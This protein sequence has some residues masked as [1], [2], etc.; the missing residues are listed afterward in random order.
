MIQSQAAQRAT[1][2]LFCALLGV[3]AAL[4]MANAGADET[5]A[6]R[7][8]ASWASSCV[9]C[10]GSGAPVKGSSIPMLAGRSASEIEQKMRAYARG[11]TPGDV[12]QQIAKGY[13]EKAVAR[14]AQWYAQLKPQASQ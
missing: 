1:R 14:I 5:L 6:A 12:M 3:G 4:S 2:R 11:N 7:Q 13:D 10:H 8:A 9:T